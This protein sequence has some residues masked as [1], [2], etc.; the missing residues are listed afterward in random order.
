MA[1]CFPSL[2]IDNYLITTMSRKVN[3]EFYQYTREKMV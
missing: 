2:A 1:L 3:V